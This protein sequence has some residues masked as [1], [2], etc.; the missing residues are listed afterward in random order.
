[1]KILDGNSSTYK[2]FAEEY[3]D[4][5]VDAAAVDYVYQQR[6][7]TPGIVKALNPEVSLD[8]IRRDIDEIGFS[9]DT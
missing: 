5:T 2:E 9:A 3:Y 7:L 1:L 8:A 4:R 6:P